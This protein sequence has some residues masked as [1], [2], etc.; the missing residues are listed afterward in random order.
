ALFF[1]PAAGL[2]AGC[3]QTTPRPPMKQQQAPTPP[4]IQ[5]GCAWEITHPQIAQCWACARIYPMRAQDLT[6]SI[7]AHSDYPNVWGL[8]FVAALQTQSADYTDVGLPTFRIPPTPAHTH[9]R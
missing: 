8:T 9:H 6:L 3:I 5:Q 2:D 7:H 1:V 4:S